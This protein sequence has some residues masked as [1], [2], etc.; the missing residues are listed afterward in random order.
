M[1]DILL[2]KTSSMGDII[3]NLP[4]VS[5]ILARMPDANIDWVAEESFADI[6]ALHPG[7]RRVIPVAVRRWRRSLLR[8]DTWSQMRRFART[9]R[10]TRYDVVLDSQGLIKSALMTRLARG[11]RCGLAWDSAWEPLA[12]LAYGRKFHVN[13]ELHAVM[14]YRQLAAQALQYSLPARLDYGIRAPACDFPWVPD[15]PYA[16][17]LHA[18]SRAEK[19]WPETAW[20]ELAARLH[21]HGIA[22]VLPWGSLAERERSVRLAAQMAQAVVAP[23]M[24]LGEAAALL[25]QAKLV[26]GVDTGLVHLA[27]AVGAPVIGIYCGSD[28]ARNGLVADTP[29]ANLGNVGLSPTVPEVVAT[30][31]VLIK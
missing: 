25:A 16:V 4:V 26:V 24:R 17:L 13:P 18:T 6:P 3:H 10:A 7:V 1:S 29:F 28:P 12:S 19:L 30:A 11:T 20:I 14:R 8:P 31:M 5:D 21:E 15:A 9:L 23:P 27:S 22:I 2:V